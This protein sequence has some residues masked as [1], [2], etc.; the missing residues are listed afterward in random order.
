MVV[1]A[2][3]ER[4]AQALLVRG[5]DGADGDRVTRDRVAALAAVQRDQA[6]RDLC[7]CLAQSAAEVL[8]GVGSPEVDLRARVAAQT[9]LG[10]DGQRDEPVVERRARLGHPHPGVGAPR[11]AD[12]ERAVLLA[13]EVHEDL[14]VE[15][16]AVEAVGSL[17]PDLLGHGHQQLQRAVRGVLVFD[18]RHH[19]GD[20]HAVV[21]AQRRPV[22]RQPL[23]VADQLDAALGGIVRAVGAALADHVEVPLE[24]QLRRILATARGRHVDDEVARAVGSNRQAALARPGAHVLD[25]R[26]LVSRRPCDLRQL[27]EVLPERPR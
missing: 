11:A 16:R 5:R 2:R 1:S 21:G 25:D 7:A 24:H 3:C 13:V 19:R 8:D 18:Q 20:R 15:Q 4:L 14:A 17:Q 6:Q 27:L 26:L 10:L 12:R 23:A 22:S 9:A